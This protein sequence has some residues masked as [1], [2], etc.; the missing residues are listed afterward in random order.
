MERGLRREWWNG[1]SP[2]GINLE[3]WVEAIN[4]AQQGGQE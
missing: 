2:L 4:Q 1:I 3:G